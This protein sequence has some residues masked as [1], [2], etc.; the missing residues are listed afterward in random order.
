MFNYSNL[1][2]YDFKPSKFKTIKIWKLYSLRI[3]NSFFFN[4]GDLE[5]KLIQ[6]NSKSIKYD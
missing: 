4:V 1:K 5:I 6:Y 3:L 2:L